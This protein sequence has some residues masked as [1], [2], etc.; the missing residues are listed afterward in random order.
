MKIYVNKNINKFNSIIELVNTITT[1]TDFIFDID[2]VI[3]KAIH[4]S[5]SCM[6]DMEIEKEFFDEYDVD[7]KTVLTLDTDLLKKIVKK[8]GKKDISM[9]LGIDNLSFKSG[10]S[11]F[12]L[13]YYVGS[14]EERAVPKIEHP[15]KL[16]VKGTDFFNNLSEAKEFSEITKLEYDDEFK[17]ISKGNMIAGESLI[18]VIENNGTNSSCWYSLDYLLLF[19]TLN[20]LNNELT[21]KFGDDLPF[22]C[23]LNI[24]NFKLLGMLAPRV[25]DVE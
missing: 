2:K 25:G 21:I 7:K 16:K 13:K 12:D 1:E 14:E 20:K 22:V 11:K 15:I 5:N 8:V 10:R 19:K 18:D 24:D 9:E 3:I 17:I 4:P 23:E 6:I